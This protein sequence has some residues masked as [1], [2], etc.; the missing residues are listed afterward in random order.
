MIHW[1]EMTAGST[2]IAV[3]YVGGVLFPAITDFIGMVHYADAAGF[4]L[5]QG[6]YF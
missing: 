4:L 3:N 1:S 5:C 2:E 6:I